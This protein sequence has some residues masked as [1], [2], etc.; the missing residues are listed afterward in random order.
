MAPKY[1]NK[2][3]FINCPFDD[4]YA[5]MFDAILFAVYDCGFRPRCAREIDDSGQIRI[6]KIIKLISDSQFGL[7]DISRTELDPINSL[8]R[9]NMPLELGLFIGANKFGN[10]FHKNKRAMIVDKEDYRYQKY[11]SDISGQDI[12]GHEN[13]P[14]KLIN[15]VRNWL[16]SMAPDQIIPG[17]ATIKRR[18]QEFQS[19]LPA[20]CAQFSLETN[21]LIYNDKSQLISVWLSTNPSGSAAA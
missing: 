17:G 3:V 15:I 6:D 1:Y 7:H 18:Y 20:L 19:Q 12:K 21:E 14:L 5:P 9:F 8:P 11:I 4:D 2:N 13:D 16:K 10:S